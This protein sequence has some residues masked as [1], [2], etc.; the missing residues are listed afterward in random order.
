MIIHG[1]PSF[2][3]ALLF[4]KKMETEFFFQ[5]LIVFRM[6]QVRRLK[7][8]IELSL[9]TDNSKNFYVIISFFQFPRVLVQVV[10]RLYRLHF[11]L[12]SLG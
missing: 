7:E 11:S 1:Q 5:I 3:I 9:N 6:N 2:V 8:I 12:L 10:I 4:G